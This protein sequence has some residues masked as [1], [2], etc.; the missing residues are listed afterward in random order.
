[1]SGLLITGHYYP[2]LDKR[3]TCTDAPNIPTALC[4]IILWRYLV[5][6]ATAAFIFVKHKLP[7]LVLIPVSSDLSADCRGAEKVNETQRATEDERGAVCGILITC[8]SRGSFAVRVSGGDKALQAYK[9]ADCGGK[10][11]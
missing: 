6:I 8:K 9:L 5:F 3:L 2:L 4:S 11:F 10:Y 1:M 7:S